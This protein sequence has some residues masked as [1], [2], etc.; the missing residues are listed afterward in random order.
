MAKEYIYLKGKVKW[1]RP[2][3]LDMQFPP[4]SWKA[5]HYLDSESKD[6]IIDLQTKGLKNKLGKDDEGYYI[7]IR[8]PSFLTVK[9]A[10]VPLQPPVVLDKDGN[11]MDD[12]QVGNGSDVTTKMEVYSHKTPQGG[13]SVAMRWESSRIDNLVPFERKSD[14]TP[15]EAKQTA[16]LVEQEPPKD[17]F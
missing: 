14:F 4:P 7:N 9:G 8:R 16:G 13:K 6:K 3:V 2:R 11:I 15:G 17:L 5:M 1:F 12:P 10:M